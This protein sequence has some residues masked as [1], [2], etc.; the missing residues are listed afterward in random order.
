MTRCSCPPQPLEYSEWTMRQAR[1]GLS[2]MNRLN[3]PPGPGP[4][5]QN[6]RQAAGTH[7]DADPGAR[8]SVRRAD[9][10]L[11][12]DPRVQ[13]GSSRPRCPSIADLHAPAVR[14]TQAYRGLAAADTH[15]GRR[16]I[17]LSR[18]AN[19][20]GRPEG[21]RRHPLGLHCN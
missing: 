9:N 13:V 7:P 14:Q 18:G 21:M 8:T 6:Y 19:L 1:F 17:D 12:S 20:G 2:D 10:K 16:A 4:L 3:L 15:V 11:A 5:Q